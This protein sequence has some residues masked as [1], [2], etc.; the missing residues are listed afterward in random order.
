MGLLGCGDRLSE[1][2]VHLTSNKTL[3]GSF[4]FHDLVL[5]V[6]SAGFHHCQ[7]YVHLVSRSSKVQRRPYFHC[8]EGWEGLLFPHVYSAPRRFAPCALGGWCDA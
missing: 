1:N 5:I 8:S 3:C 4:C 7:S 2:E 6:E